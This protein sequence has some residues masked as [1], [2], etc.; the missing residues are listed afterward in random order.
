MHLLDDIRAVAAEEVAGGVEDQVLE[1]NGREQAPGAQAT[2]EEQAAALLA[3]LRKG[4]RVGLGDA[5]PG[6]QHGPDAIEPEH[7][8]GNL[9]EEEDQPDQGGEDDQ[10]SL[11]A[12]ANAAASDFHRAIKPPA[13]PRP[14]RVAG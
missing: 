3:T 6:R 12:L 11:H 9:V 1:H 2:V 10:R 14:P 13:G 7:A 8:A 4:G 5:A